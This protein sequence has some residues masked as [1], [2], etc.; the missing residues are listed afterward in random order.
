[1]TAVEGAAEAARSRGFACARDRSS[2]RRRGARGGARFRGCHPRS[3]ITHLPPP[4]CIIGAGETTVHV[5]GGGIGGR[6]QEFA[7]AMLRYLAVPPTPGSAGRLDPPYRPRVGSIGTDG[8]DGPYGCRRRDRRF[9]DRASG[10]AARDLDPRRFLD[11][12]DSYHF[13]SA[14]DD[15]ASHRPYRH[16]RWRRPGRTDRLNAINRSNSDA[17]QGARRSPDR[18]RVS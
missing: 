12:N 6:N 2:D 16:E 17:L 1:M 11:N 3:T 10:A 5:K 14:L 15:L 7:L 13:F 8:I 18:R 4:A 9:D